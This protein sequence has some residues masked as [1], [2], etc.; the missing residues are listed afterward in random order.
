MVRACRTRSVDLTA[1]S[2][3]TDSPPRV[4]FSWL[5]RS[6]PLSTTIAI[7]L[8]GWDSAARET[9]PSLS[10]ALCDCGDGENPKLAVMDACNYIRAQKSVTIRSGEP[11]TKCCTTR[12]QIGGQLVLSDFEKPPIYQSCLI[13]IS[14]VTH[15]FPDSGRE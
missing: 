4:S 1:T 8:R 2:I 6:P 3:R 15:H 9:R 13:E 10:M 12:R 5:R 7:T 14:M 11:R